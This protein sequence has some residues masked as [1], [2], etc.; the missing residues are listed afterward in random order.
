M[1]IIDTFKTFANNQYVN[2]NN[3]VGN[4]RSNYFDSLD[5]RIEKLAKKPN[6]T[7]K[8]NVELEKLRK[9]L[10]SLEE[11]VEYDKDVKH[12]L[13]IYFFKVKNFDG[14]D[15][16]SDA[17]IS[18]VIYFPGNTM[19]SSDLMKPLQLL[20]NYI[21]QSMLE[22]D[23][24]LDLI[25]NSSFFPE[26]SELKENQEYFDKNKRFEI[27]AIK[28]DVNGEGQISLKYGREEIAKRIGEFAKE[29]NIDE[30]N[31]NN[32]TEPIVITN[33]RKKN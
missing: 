24:G 1:S 13:G 15:D 12:R 26:Y 7:D 30:P 9:Q 27:A 19:G 20:S 33:F 11:S 5:E 21:S 17:I 2:I 14:S 4:I 31:L 32:A 10:S 23:K 3:A 25:N 16:G 28:D 29:N 8:E 22:I 6:R 18:N